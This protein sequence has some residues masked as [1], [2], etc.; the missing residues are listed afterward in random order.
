MKGGIKKRDIEGSTI[1]IKPIAFL[2]VLV[3]LPVHAEIELKFQGVSR[4][5]QTQIIDYHRYDYESAIYKTK[6]HRIVRVDAAPLR[7]IQQGA[8]VVLSLFPDVAVTFRTTEIFERGNNWSWR[9]EDRDHEIFKAFEDPKKFEVFKAHVTEQGVPATLPDSS[10]R[11]MF[12]PHAY[13][14]L[15][16]YE[17]SAENVA[18]N[19]DR[20]EYGRFENWHVEADGVALVAPTHGNTIGWAGPPPQT[21]E[22][23]AM[24][25]EAQR[26]T[27]GGFVSVLVILPHRGIG[28]GRYRIVPFSHDPAYA[29]VVELDPDVPQ[30]SACLDAPC[31]RPPA[32]RAAMQEKA[33]HMASYAPADPNRQ[34]RGP[35]E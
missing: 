5:I 31:D 29:L 9:G 3:A 21:P 11:R 18:I 16:N 35:L 6:R 12:I 8:D 30:I 26:A 10:L 28:G 34:V 4:D 1:V 13:I 2:A 15:A 33:H 14:G 19:A 24:A 27:R 20:M 25:R 32:I 22:E 17:V 23:I 7:E